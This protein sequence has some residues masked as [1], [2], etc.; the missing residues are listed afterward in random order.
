MNHSSLTNWIRIAATAGLSALSGS[1]F[2]APLTPGTPVAIPHTHGKFDFIRTD[3]YAHRLLLGHEGNGSFDIFD[4]DARTAIAEVPTGTAQDAAVDARRGFY[5][6]SGNNPGRTVIVDARSFA[7]VAEVSLPADTDLI[8]YDAATRLVHESNDTAAEEWLIDPATRAVVSTIRFKGHGVEDLAF[9]PHYRKLYQ[10]VKGSNTI[11]EVDPTTQVVL[12][13]WPLAP[14]KSP[15]GI[16]LDAAADRLLVACEGRL[17]LM[18]ASNGAILDRAPIAPRVDEIAYDASRHTAYC[19]ARTGLISVVRLSGD[20]LV[21]LGDVHD[22]KT[23]SIAVDPKTHLVWIAYG[24]KAGAW[25]QP[26]T[27]SS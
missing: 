27:P 24:D 20:K 18:N 4:L 8:G 9:T 14:D 1:A 2:A 12:H 21:P 22:A 26:F 11:A 17:V 10:A 16:A 19:A 7:I 25:V 13:Q 5:F 15:H 23:G 6:V 3:T